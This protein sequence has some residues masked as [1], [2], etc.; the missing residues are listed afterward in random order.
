MAEI[1]EVPHLA[2]Q[3]GVTE[4]EVGRRGVEAGL[5]GERLAGRARR[6]R[7]WRAAAPRRPGRR[8]RARAARA[9]LRL[10]R[11]P[12]LMALSVQR[13]ARGWTRGV[14]EAARRARGC[15]RR[16]PATSAPGGRRPLAAHARARKPPPVQARRAAASATPRCEPDRRRGQHAG[17]AGQGLGLDAALEAADLHR[18]A[19]GKAHEVDVGAAGRRSPDGGAAARRARRPE[20]RAGSSARAARSAARR[21]SG[22]RPRWRAPSTSSTR[23][24]GAARRAAAARSRS[25]SR[26]ARRAPGRRR[27]RSRSRRAQPSSKARRAAQRVPLRQ[28]AGRQAV[29]VPVVHAHAPSAVGAR[30]K[31]PS[32]P[33]DRP[34]RHQ[35]R[36]LLGRGRPAGST[37]ARKSLPRP[38]RLKNSSCVAAR[39]R[40]CA[41]AARR[42]TT[43]TSG[44]GVALVARRRPPRRGRR[45]RGRGASPRSMQLELRRSARA[46]QAVELAAG[47]RDGR[48]GSRRRPASGLR[49]QTRRTRR[50]LGEREQARRR[51]RREA[52]LV[53]DLL[54]AGEGAL[55]ARLERCRARS[56]RRRSAGRSAPWCRGRSRAVGGTRGRAASPQPR[57]AAR[58]GDRR[59]SRPTPSARGSSETSTPSAF[60][61]RPRARR[62]ARGGGIG[63]ER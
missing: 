25:R 30:T 31:R 23:S 14:G 63:R 5:D 54:L 18:R 2:Q 43:S 27:S 7:A 49:S 58:A 45:R 62:A 61:L 46:V 57:S 29:G 34:R 24:C 37:S 44:P 20:R 21:R 12:T 3:H 51:R 33:S 6:A 40:G 42:T 15:A 39:A 52:V 19:I 36:D 4:V 16:R 48:R 35:A 60:G 50:G 32:A 28:S 38:R 8:R 55:D 56:P 1:L 13:G 59:G 41:R 47:S 26:R 53:V 10:G 17:A 9:G 11:T 22:S